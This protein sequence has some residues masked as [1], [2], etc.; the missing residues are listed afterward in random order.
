MD[1]TFN[2]LNK[3]FPEHSA[4]GYKSSGLNDFHKM[5]ILRMLRPDRLPT[6]LLEYTHNHLAAYDPEEETFNVRE[7]LS[8]AR[9]H[10][11]VLVLL[12]SP[13]HD[14][15]S[16]AAS[17]LKLTI[18]PVEELINLAKVVSLF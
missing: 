10:W 12:P 2:K 13:A 7:V 11:G 16:H 15:N 8:D 6:A 3:L 18:S 1:K 5:L 4:S 14:A 17:R 9:K